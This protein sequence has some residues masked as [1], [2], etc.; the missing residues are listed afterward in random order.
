MPTPTRIT[1]WPSAKEATRCD[2][3]GEDIA[4]GETIYGVSNKKFH[5]QCLSDDAKAALVQMAQAHLP[6][7]PKETEYVERNAIDGATLDKLGPDDITL[8]TA[9]KSAVGG[10]ASVDR[11]QV[12]ALVDEK[13]AGIAKPL[14][15]QVERRGI[16]GPKI[17]QAHSEMPEVLDIV[18]TV[19][20]GN[21]LNAVL[22]GPAGSGKTYLAKQLAKALGLKYYF[23][24]LSGGTT[25]AHLFGRKLPQEDGT[26]GY[27]RS[28]FVKAYEEGGVFLLDE[29]DRSDPNV[30]TA[31]NAALANGHMEVPARVDNPYAV[32]H[33][34]FICIGS[35]NTWGHGRDM[36]YVGA[37][38][39][40]GAT[41][42]RFH[43]VFMGYDEGLE[44][45]LA[46]CPA[47]VAR[48]QTI[49]AKAEQ[50]GLRR[51]VSMRKTIEISARHKSKGGK[52][53]T[54]ECA[55]RL[56][57][58][59]SVEDQKTVGVTPA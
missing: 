12:E 49:R 3:C 37:S 5:A 58:S 16:E 54:T 43:P 4:I 57:K 2:A 30:L 21:R 34:D 35:M 42:D 22:V 36:L 24:G 31:L 41:M 29:M 6:D 33:Q 56:V 1:T 27:E 20:S 7:L 11:E 19:V 14:T 52:L 18:S 40:D 46:A 10:S 9:L 38:A 13:L 23:K 26:W 25:E 15:I 45:E 53:T 17:E 39:Q 48:F 47:V 55:Q 28:T 32:R 50:A 8:L 59:W 51:A 44:A